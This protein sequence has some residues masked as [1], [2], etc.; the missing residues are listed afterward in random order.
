MWC[1]DGVPLFGYRRRSY[2]VLCGLLGAAAWGALATIVHNKYAAVS[3]ILLSSLSVAFSDVV[4]M[5]SDTMS[6]TCQKIDTI[7]LIL[8]SKY[9]CYQETGCNS[10]RFCTEA[11]WEL[12][13]S[14][15]RLVTLYL[16]RFHFIIL[17]ISLLR[18]QFC[19]FKGH[20]SC[21]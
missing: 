8:D 11:N 21:Y 1:S 20:V 6:S 12:H 9:S 5:T 15:C 4:S 16:G 17:I 3:A 2:L 13:G 18:S 7:L 19:C 10:N 14:E